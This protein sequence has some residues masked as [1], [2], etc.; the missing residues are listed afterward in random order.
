[1]FI[2]VCVVDDVIIPNYIVYASVLLNY[3]VFIY[4]AIIKKTEACMK[5]ILLLLILLSPLSTAETVTASV[6]WL[7]PTARNDGSPLPGEQIVRYNVYYSLDTVLYGPGDLAQ[8]ATT[9][10]NG[11][12]IDIAMELSPG[13]Y[14]LRLAIETIDNNNHPSELSE[15][16]EIPFSVSSNISPLPPSNILINFDCTPD[17]TVTR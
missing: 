8:I 12:S 11:T 10:N 17:C 5:Y 16:Q 4:N 6:G 14:V 13:N 3:L 9:P 1:M 7:K 15:I 2:P